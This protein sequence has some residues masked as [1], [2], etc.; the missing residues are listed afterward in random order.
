VQSAFGFFVRGK[1]GS[2]S[3]R[4][5]NWE[6]ARCTC[7]SAARDANFIIFYGIAPNSCVVVGFCPHIELAVN[8]LELQGTMVQELELV[9][10]DALQTDDDDGGVPAQ[11]DLVVEDEQQQTETLAALDT[12]RKNRHFCDVV[13]NVSTSNHTTLLSLILL[14]TQLKWIC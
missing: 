8:A 10:T 13:L 1:V 6:H 11:Q 3:G 12:M 14:S 2:R 5:S 7:R 9:P 4:K